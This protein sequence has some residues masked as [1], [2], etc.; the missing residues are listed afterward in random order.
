MS[1]EVV[2]PQL[3]HVPLDMD[4]KV[5]ASKKSGRGTYLGVD[6]AVSFWTLEGWHDRVKRASKE[7]GYM[8]AGI[9]VRDKRAS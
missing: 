5:P 8:E 4:E 2:M 3:Y 7:D 6:G 9:A 1:F